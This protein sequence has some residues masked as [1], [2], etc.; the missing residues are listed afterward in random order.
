MAAVVVA[1]LWAGSAAA[2][3]EAGIRYASD[4][5]VPISAQ[6]GEAPFASLHVTSEVRVL[7]EVDGAVR[8]AATGVARLAEDGSVDEVFTDATN[9]TRIADVLDASLVEVAPTQDG[10]AD[11]RIEGW[12]ASASLTDSL[13]GLFAEADATYSEHCTRCHVGYAAP[14]ETMRSTLPNNRVERIIRNMARGIDIDDRQVN[15]IIQW[16]QKHPDD[17]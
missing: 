9:A 2:Q 5:L 7:D 11:V 17:L 6:P 13:D 16:F 14:V 3:D 4:H 12:L 8:V 1:L 10:W 15:L